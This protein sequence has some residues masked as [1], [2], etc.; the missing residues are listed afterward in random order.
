LAT[1]DAQK[2]YEKYG[3]IKV[4]AEKYMRKDIIK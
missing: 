2:L 4:D 1:R 3:F